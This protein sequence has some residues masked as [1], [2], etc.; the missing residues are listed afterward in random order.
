M[1]AFV[2]NRPNLPL[3][4]GEGDAYVYMYVKRVRGYPRMAGEKTHICLC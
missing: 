3:A 1:E 2:W 4:G